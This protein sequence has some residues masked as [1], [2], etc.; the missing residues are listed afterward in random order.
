MTIVLIGKGLL[1][2]GWSP[3][4][5]NKQVLG[6]SQGHDSKTMCNDGDDVSTRPRFRPKNPLSS[7]FRNI[8]QQI[9][10]LLGVSWDGRQAGV[11]IP[12][13]ILLWQMEVSPNSLVG[14]SSELLPTA[15]SKVWIFQK[16]G[17]G[18]WI[19]DSDD[20]LEH[21]VESFLMFFFDEQNSHDFL[22]GIW[23]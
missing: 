15:E 3:K 17:E 23:W 4:R 20:F 5:G 2:E 9:K 7:L 18:N 12:P 13:R 19:R 21:Q 11:P 16:N 8:N 1:L 10:R 22:G 14:L 6:S